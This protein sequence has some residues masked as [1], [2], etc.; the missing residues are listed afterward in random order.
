MNFNKIKYKKNNKMRIHRN[1]PN[2][3]MNFWGKL[4]NL[5]DNHNKIIILLRK[6]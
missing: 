1:I 2:I 4:I 3:W 6:T 5:L